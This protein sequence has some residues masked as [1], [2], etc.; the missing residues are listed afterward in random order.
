M[1]TEIEAL[2]KA[3]TPA[4]QKAAQ[5]A[6]AST[7]GD[8]FWAEVDRLLNKNADAVLPRPTKAAK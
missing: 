1:K 2:K 4:M 6:A 3:Y 8:S 7:R 5:T